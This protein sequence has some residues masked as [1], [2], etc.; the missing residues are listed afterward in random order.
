[1]TLMLSTEICNYLVS[2]GVTTHLDEIRLPD[3]PIPAIA[4]IENVGLAPETIQDSRI[5]VIEHPRMQILC[6]D[7]DPQVA[8]DNAWTIYRILA[9]LTN[10]ALMNNGIFVMLFEVS[11][12]PFLVE[13]D[14]N[15]RPIYGFN[16]QLTLRR[17]A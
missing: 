2:Q 12:P 10:S 4:V 5:P 17:T 9:N 8:Y 7:V 11:Q 15:D 16:A 14:R 1:M 6:R 3:S 13:R